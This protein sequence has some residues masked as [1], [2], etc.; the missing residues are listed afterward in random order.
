MAKDTE[1]P[2]DNVITNDDGTSILLTDADQPKDLDEGNGYDWFKEHGK[3]V[4]EN[5][6]VV[7]DE[8]FD[9]EDGDED[10]PDKGADGSPST[11]TGLQQ[12]PDVGLIARAV[13]AGLKPEQI[14]SLTRTGGLQ[15]TIEVLEA[16]KGSDGEA[17]EEGLK[18]FELDLDP[19]EYDEGV[20]ETLNKMND[21]HFEQVKALRDEIKSLKS[22]RSEEKQQTEQQKQQQHL[23]WVDN[24]FATMHKENEAYG[25]IFGD[26]VAAEMNDKD[27]D[28]RRQFANRVAVV[29]EMR[30]QRQAHPEKSDEDLLNIAIRVA[31][32]DQITKIAESTVKAK[33]KQHR[34][35]RV[36][37]RS[38][39]KKGSERKV[40]S[41]GRG[42][43]T[44]T[45]WLKGKLKSM[46]LNS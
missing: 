46:G 24:R 5:G 27:E 22:E 37:S 11:I 17:E 13:Q 38:T 42:Q 7:D 2:K 34:N 30:R 1:E 14:Q 15:D 43:K 19:E 8:D 10:P 39:S 12:E 23:I 35:N 33:V 18:K 21:Y 9:D 40:E 29:Q 3:T 36:S 6:E 28:A 25:D 44:A 26:K 31:L 16:N 20:I 4:D 32:P 45:S 41:T